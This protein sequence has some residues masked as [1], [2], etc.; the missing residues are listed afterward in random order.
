MTPRPTKTTQPTSQRTKLRNITLFN[1][2]DEPTKKSSSPQTLRIDQI[3][4]GSVQ[5]RHYF[6]SDKLEQLTQSVK[7]YGI[8]EPI[9][10]RALSDNKFEL[11]A[12]ERR[13]RAANAAGL[14]EVPVVIKDLTDTQA[15]QLA[16]IENLQR[17]DL[18][19][20]EEVEGILQLIALQKNLEKEDVIS[21]LYRMYNEVKGNINSSNPNVR[22]N[23][24]DDSIKGIFES[25]LGINW[26]SFVKNKLPLL[27]LPQDILEVLR[28][29]KIEY[30]KA[31][32]LASLK[33]SE[34]RKE[35]MT[36]ALA[37]SLSLREI[38]ERIKAVKPQPEKE[39]IFNRLDN[40]HKQVKKSKKLI[41]GNSRKRKK[42]ESLLAQIERLFEVDNK[43]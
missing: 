16:L 24:F 10:V 6:D 37:N 17:E 42:L 34:T 39:E 25:V 26:E 21:K 22:V 9:L 12:G 30:T 13:Y 20:V 27:N 38:K 14:M 40:V 23:E 32:A 29:G 18:N 28:Q 41:L 2:E 35:L 5:P 4:T 8:L 11:V 43:G 19:P 31:K 15:L 36:E 7:E 1:E 33:D 3:V